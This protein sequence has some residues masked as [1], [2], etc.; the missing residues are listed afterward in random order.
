MLAAWSHFLSLLFLLLNLAYTIK[1]NNQIK[2]YYL[3]IMQSIETLSIKEIYKIHNRLP[4]V[5][6][7]GLK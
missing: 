2:L 3:I 7:N 6:E 5:E 1:F 4:I